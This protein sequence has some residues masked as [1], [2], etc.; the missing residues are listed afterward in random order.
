MAG[1]TL[2]SQSNS[3]IV[4]IAEIGVNHDGSLDRAHQMVEA[5]AAAGFD[6]VKFQYWIDDELFAEDVPAPPYQQVT[7][8]REMAAPLWLS[9]SSLEML[10]RQASALGIGFGVTPDGPR[11]LLEVKELSPSFIKV[12]SGDADNPWLLEEALNCHC[13]I[14][15]STGMMDD[16]ELFMMLGRVSHN[17]NTTFL[18]CI[19][20]YPTLVREANLHRLRRIKVA[21][22][23]P[24]GFSDHTIGIV[25]SA[26]AIA[27]GAE[28]IEKH[29]TWSTTAKGP[30]HSCSLPLAQAAEWV[31]SL[32][33]MAEGLVAPSLAKEEAV[34]KRFVRKALYARRPITAGDR[35][36]LD[37]LCALRPLEDGIPANQRDRIIG[38]AVRQEVAQG[39]RLRWSDFLPKET[40]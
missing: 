22:G 34:N 37:D 35:V 24:V 26:G 13:P 27:M 11:A 38:R 5:V 40:T 7:S 18:H 19:S 17:K 21:T 3:P 8:Q 16:S 32:R 15:I 4:L 6:Y 29:V 30:D 20:A 36:V 39:Q 25:A 12:G 10:H 33:E 28:V 1:R 2:T 23:R 9:V 14:V 31:G